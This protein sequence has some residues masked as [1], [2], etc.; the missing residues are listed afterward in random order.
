LV[1]SH[2]T[3]FALICLHCGISL[4]GVDFEGIEVV[5]DAGDVGRQSPSCADYANPPVS[6]SSWDLQG[7]SVSYPQPPSVA[8]ICLASVSPTYLA[9]GRLVEPFSPSASAVVSLL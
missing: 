3:G 9:H 5:P 2:P 6:F 4:P 1:L 8:G 7:V